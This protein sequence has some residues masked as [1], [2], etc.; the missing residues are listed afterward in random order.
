[1]KDP[2]TFQDLLRQIKNL[3]G[4]A[5]SCV[6]KSFHPT[7]S[8]EEMEKKIEELKKH[9]EDLHQLNS[10]ELDA[11][12]LTLEGAEEIAKSLRSKASEFTAIL[13]ELKNLEKEAE[14]AKNKMQQKIYAPVKRAESSSKSQETINEDKFGKKRQGKFK[15]LGAKKNWIP[16]G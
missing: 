1:M 8:E 15:L 2:Q 14:L 16:L 6:N 10:K 13:A 5:N 3:V 9:L 12:H 7:L 11:S 4:L